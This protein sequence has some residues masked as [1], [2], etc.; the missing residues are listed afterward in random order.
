M[1]IAIKGVK[2][3]MHTGIFLLSIPPEDLRKCSAV[4][5]GSLAKPRK[6]QRRH[7]SG[8]ARNIAYKGFS[9]GLEGYLLEVARIHQCIVVIDGSERRAKFYRR[10]R[11]ERRQRGRLFGL[12]LSED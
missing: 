4:T 12:P 8:Y 2:E 11:R 9:E 1:Q 3:K 10:E 7:F 5:T 6:V